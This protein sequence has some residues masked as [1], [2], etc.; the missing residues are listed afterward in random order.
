LD[1]LVT[2][3]GISNTQHRLLMH[4]Y[5]TECKPTQT[6]LARTFD[7]STAA[8]TSMLKK[9]ES[10]GLIS[11]IQSAEDNRFNRITI[12]NMGME[13]ITRTRELFSR[14]DQAMFSRFTSEELEDFIQS[15]EKLGDTLK[16]YEESERNSPNP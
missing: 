3:F 7:V 1:G 14:V 5:R 6:E 13:M 12:T 11:R 2:E 10:E 8:I 16:A 15:L 4:L 9:L